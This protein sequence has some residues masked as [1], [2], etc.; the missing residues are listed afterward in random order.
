M[1]ESASVSVSVSVSESESV[2]VSEYVS[3]S[4]SVSVSA[5]ASRVVPV[6]APRRCATVARMRGFYAIVDPELCGD[7]DP[8]WVAREI[9]EGGCALLQLRDK[10]DGDHAARAL[11]AAELARACAEAAVPFVVNDHLALAVQVGAW[12]VHLGQGDMPLEQAR[13]LAPDLRVGLSTHSPEQAAD[14][15]RRGADLIGF[16]PVFSTR[17]KSQPDPTVGVDA[18]A[19]TCAATARPVVA[20]GGIGLAELPAVVATGVP[21]VAAIAAVCGAADPR[22]AARAFHR[23]VRAG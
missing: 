13:A 21:L 1:P 15:L 7:R 23:A 12:G 20:I 10:R 18:L 16:G 17:S 8:A 14:A 2:S 19:R 6:L 5:S 4:V 9:L 3:V 11:L 22:A